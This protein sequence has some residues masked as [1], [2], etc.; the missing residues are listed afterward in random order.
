MDVE[1]GEPVGQHGADEVR[2]AVAVEIRA[3]EHGVDIRVAAAAQQVVD[4]A[5][6]GIDA[7]LG[8]AVGGDGRERAEIRQAR[9]QPVEGRDMGALKLA[10]ARRPEPFTRIVPVPDVEVADLCALD[11][12]DAEKMP[13]RYREGEARAGGNDEPLDRAAFRGGEPLVEAAVEAVGGGAAGLIG[14]GRMRHRQA[15]Q[16]GVT[17]RMARLRRRAYSSPPSRITATISTRVA[18]ARMVGS[19]V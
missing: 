5:A 14:G 6:I 9:P 19:I 13:G 18:T 3:G 7:V 2:M 12:D 4:A 11:R 10:R 15:G 17:W 16:V 8:E 1:L